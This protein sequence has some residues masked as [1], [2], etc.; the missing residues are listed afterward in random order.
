VVLLASF[1]TA[2]QEE[3][4]RQF[5]VAEREAL[6]AMLVVRANAVREA[7]RLATQENATCAAVA[8]QEEAARAARRNLA[9]RQANRARQTNGKGPNAIDAGWGDALM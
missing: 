9:H 8:V 6:V 1:E 5:M 3:V 7:A 4:T 2:H